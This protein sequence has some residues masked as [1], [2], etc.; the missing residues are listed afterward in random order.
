MNAAMPPSHER[1]RAR[2][3]A[4]V[5]PRTFHADTFTLGLRDGWE[6]ESVYVLEGPREHDLQHNITVNV[7]PDAPD[8]PLLD[9]A[10]LQIQMQQETLKGCRLLMKRHTQLDDGVPAYRAIFVWSPTED[11]RLYQDLLIVLHEEVG[12]RL[13]A[14]FTKK[15]RKTLGPSVERAMRTFEPLAHRKSQFAIRQS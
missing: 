4:A 6:D 14:S 1:H 12:Y 10:D 3:G 5:L 9:Y 15:T 8:V 11:R 7:D 2:S 13:T